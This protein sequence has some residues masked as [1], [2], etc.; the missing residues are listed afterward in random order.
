MLNSYFIDKIEELLEKIRIKD[1]DRS[2]QTLVG[3][4]P[5]YIYIYINIYIFVISEEEIVT[6]VSD[7]VS[8]CLAIQ[9]GIPQGS[10]LGPLLFLFYIYINDL[11]HH[12]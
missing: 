9:F 11:P 6:V 3:C 4:N 5:N 2:L 7:E 10:I 1:S 12:I 8:D